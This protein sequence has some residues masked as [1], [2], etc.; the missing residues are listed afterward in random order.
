MFLVNSDPTY[1]LTLVLKIQLTIGLMRSAL[2]SEPGTNSMAQIYSPR[3]A[4]TN[5]PINTSAI[6]QP[7]I[8]TKGDSASLKRMIHE[9]EDPEVQLAPTRP[10]TH[11]HTNGRETPKNRITEG[12]NNLVGK[13]GIGSIE[14]SLC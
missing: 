10:R 8:L 5:L 13:V 14:P 11:L 9:V 4:L 3:R 6:H 7:A 1:H 2:S 12:M